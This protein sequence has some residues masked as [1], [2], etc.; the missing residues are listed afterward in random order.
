M[1]QDIENSPHPYM[2]HWD[3]ELGIHITLEQWEKIWTAASKTSICTTLKENLYKIMFEWYHTPFLLQ[4]LFPGTTSACWRCNHNPATIYHIF[5]T[6]PVISALWDKT[7]EIL[8][9][10]TCFSLQKD[11]LLYLLGL[12]LQGVGKRTQKVVQ[13]ILL[14]MRC[15]IAAHWKSPTMPTIPDL[16]NKIQFIWNMDYLMAMLHDKAL[17][18]A[19][20]WFLWDSYYG[21]LHNHVETI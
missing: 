13:S 20:D 2:Q 15:L 18:F 1:D 3:T 17:P 16:I 7:S 19:E 4:K 9:K 11:P 21:Q 5:W 12:P 6:C 14:G 8:S 10:I